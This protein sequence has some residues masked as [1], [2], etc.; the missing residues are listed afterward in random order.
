MATE[1]EVCRSFLRQTAQMAEEKAP[2]VN[3]YTAMTK[4]QLTEVSFQVVDDALQLFGGYGYLKD[5]PIEKYFRDL[6]SL[7]ILEGTNEIM[8]L[9]ISRALLAD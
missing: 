8:L 9:I 6:R 2:N 5:Y 4:R 7:R 1:V 3:V